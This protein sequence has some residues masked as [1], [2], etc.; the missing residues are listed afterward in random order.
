[1]QAYGNHIQG[2]SWGGYLAAGVSVSVSY[3]SDTTIQE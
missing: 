2:Q 1:M 3:P